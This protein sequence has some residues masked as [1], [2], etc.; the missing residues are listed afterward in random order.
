MMGRLAALAFSGMLA[1][2]AAPAAADPALFA[3]GT[4]SGFA[5]LRLDGAD[6]E[7]SAGKGGYGKL[8][9]SGAGSGVA[10]R[11]RLDLATLA[12]RPDLG[13]DLG[14]Y[15]MVQ[16]QQGQSPAVDVG[17]AY[18]IYKPVPRSSVRFQVRTGLFWPPV[19]LEHDGLAWTTTRTLTPSALNSWIAQEVK[20]AGV[21]A[22]LSE[23]AGGHRLIF[24]AAAFGDN[25]TSGTVL[26]WRGWSLDGRR[27]SLLAD[28]PLP[29]F[30]PTRS[31][32]FVDQG[33]YAHPSLEMDGRVGGYARLEWRPPWP[34]AVHLFVYDNAGNPEVQKDEQWAWR[35]Q[36]GEAGLL[37]EPARDW[38]ILAQ[39]LAGR[40][41]FGPQTPAGR[42]V[43]LDYAAAYL[44]VSHDVGRLRIATRGDWFSTH[45]RSFVL[46]DNND[47]RGW[48]ATAD[49]SWRLSAHFSVWCEL[50]HVWSDR[51]ARAYLLAAPV[52][53]Q[54]KL[55]FALRARL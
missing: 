10:V 6:G 47:E 8:D 32:I 15:V 34:L 11:P 19:S 52:Q 42:Y 23:E 53:D 9:A 39:G 5:D 1:A 21:E 45:D 16:T 37:A 25:D 17:E 27:T 50:V 12:W 55:T 31:A 46:L 33:H 44:L 22:T 43:D 30:D 2:A 54:T 3:P 14:A 20:V 13:G 26:A 36:F 24:T 35:T 4:L 40:T 49:A 41:Y 38:Q 18:L 51:P 28:M 7:L 29:T 48:A